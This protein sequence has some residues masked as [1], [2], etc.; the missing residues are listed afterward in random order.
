M[1]DISN[2]SENELLQLKKQI[3]TKLDS[4]SSA[5]VVESLT[6]LDSLID[7]C[8]HF[9]KI[10]GI[11]MKMDLRKHSTEEKV[12]LEIIDT[13]DN[14]VLF[15]HYADLSDFKDL[16]DL[17]DL[18]NRHTQYTSLYHI[19][20]DLTD[21]KII[22]FKK[23]RIVIDFSYKN[24]NFSIVD[25]A[26]EISISARINL[27]HGSANYVFVVGDFT[28]D[29]MNPEESHLVFELN[30]RTTI[31]NINQIDLVLDRLCEDMFEKIE[32]LGYYQ[33]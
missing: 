21:F 1:I 14:E 20:E 33:K 18:V 32:S 22:C 8:E 27:G 28:L 9:N 24:V 7:R 12:L 23:D 17:I 19:I 31:Y 2:L 11:G 3:E 6:D 29:V 15:N 26:N 16:I 10:C 25:E 4:L 30:R 5:E 13:E